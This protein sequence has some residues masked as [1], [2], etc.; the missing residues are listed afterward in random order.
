MPD[1]STL[2]PPIQY[3]KIWLII[4][5]GLIIFILIWYAVAYWLTRR[6]PV[7]SLNTLKPLPTGAELKRL[8]ARYLQLIEEIYQRYLRQEISLR[9]LHQQLSTTVR[10]FAYEAN[11]FP[12]PYLTLSDLQQSPYPTLATLIATYYPEEFAAIT[13]GD[14][15]VS[16]E[17]AKGVVTRW[18][19]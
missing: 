19:F 7:K 11:H 9:K 4:G 18:P 6:K 17:A 3:S 12:A 13:K 16:V 2:N 5:L 14:A 10:A 1:A 8:K 15:A